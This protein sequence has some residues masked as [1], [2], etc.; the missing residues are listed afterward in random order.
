MMT[1]Q[2]RG[3]AFTL[4]RWQWRSVP[5]FALGGLLAVLLHHQLGLGWKLPIPPITI[6]GAALGIFIIFRTNSSYD[7]WWEGRKLWG[8]LIT[9]SRH[10]ATQV[11]QY[12]ASNDPDADAELAE[13][14][15]RRQIAYVHGLR[16]ALRGQD[17]FHD[18][19][20]VLY[21]GDDLELMR[22]QSSINHAL[23]NLQ[24]HDLVDAA[25]RGALGELRL[26]K[27]DESIA[28]L[29]DIQGC[30]ERIQNTPLPR[31]YAFLADQLIRWYGFI[32][33]FA[34]VEELGWLIIPVNI[35]VCLS[36]A[37]ISG[38]SRSLEDPFNLLFNGLPLMAI[39][40][41][42]EVNLLQTIGLAEDLPEMLTPDERGILM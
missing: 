9:T 39:S 40:R 1:H 24:T 7:R 28:R 10:F 15:V 38:V 32:L 30:C 35:L 18:D 4:L 22:S 2:S 17:H 23:I 41:L 42:I 13:R 5:Q 21:A 19:D 11:T 33:P 14:L 31:G 34:F 27:I 25:S 3:S 26:Q 37:L 16:L 12:L 29:L 36:F 20:F 8:R 6:M